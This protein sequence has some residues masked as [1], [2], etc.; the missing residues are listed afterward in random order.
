MF[1]HLPKAYSADYNAT[2]E[3]LG[4]QWSIYSL[5]Y[6]NDGNVTKTLDNIA[7]SV[8]NQIRSAIYSTNITGR[9]MYPTVFIEVVW[10][11][12]V[13]P[14]VLTISAAFLLVVTI[15]LS[16]GRRAVV[17]K[18]SSLALLFHG[19]SGIESDERPEEVEG[20]KEKAKQMTV[21]LCK[22][23]GVGVTRLK[24]M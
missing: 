24:V 8:T 15:C 4:I 19:I 9:V 20:M 1:K 21:N 14:I 2:Y 6:S 7:L 5:Y 13:L 23:D 3:A 11:W 10:A 22:D 16:S 12:Y 17:W 18:S